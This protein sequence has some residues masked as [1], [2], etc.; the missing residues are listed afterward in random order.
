[1]I[2]PNPEIESIVANATELSKSLSHEYVTLE[3]LLYA[4][5]GHKPFGDLLGKYGADLGGLKA[6]IVNYLQNQTY[7]V[8]EFTSTPKKNTGA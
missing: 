3:H 8:N 6:D 4:I 2:H 7:M 1:M 5:V